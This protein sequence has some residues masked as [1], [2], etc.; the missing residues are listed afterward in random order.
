[1]KKIEISLTIKQ[2]KDLNKYLLQFWIDAG[3]S[4]VVKVVLCS[5][6][7]LK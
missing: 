4:S 2:L 6:S 5:G 7:L 3:C 1:M